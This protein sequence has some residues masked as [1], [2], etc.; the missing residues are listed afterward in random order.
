MLAAMESERSACLVP[1]S[2]GPSG[3]VHQMVI[4]GSIGS[5]G[6]VFLERNDKDRVQ[7]R[8]T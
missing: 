2:G 4:S 8:Q 1:P 7:I 3:L 5:A 6:S